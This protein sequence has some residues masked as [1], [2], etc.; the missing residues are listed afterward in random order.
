[1][2]KLDV[3][4]HCAHAHVQVVAIDAARGDLDDYIAG[5]RFGIGSV[6]VLEN[7]RLPEFLNHRSFHATIAFRM[8]GQPVEPG[9]LIL[10]YRSRRDS[11]DP[12][13]FTAAVGCR[14]DRT[15]RRTHIPVNPSASP[16]PLHSEK[17]DEAPHRMNRFAR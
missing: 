2:G 6:F 13:R 16:Q 7:I 8:N 4:H 5:P 15:W 14:T 12:A 17:R 10:A 9:W 3:G 11:R 1:V